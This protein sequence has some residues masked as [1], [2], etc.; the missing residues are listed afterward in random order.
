MHDHHGTTA[1]RELAGIT[2]GDQAAGQRRTQAADTFLGGARADAFVV[3]DGDLFGR[4]AHDLVGHTHRDGD[5]G[6]FVLE[7]TGGQSGSGFLLAGG[8]VLVHGVATDV[9]TLGHLFS[10]LQHVPV[11]FGLVFHEPGVG[12][13][14]GVHLL[15]HAGNGFHTTG[16]IHITLVGNDALRRRGNGLQAA[17]T[18]AVD[19]HA[20]H[21]DRAACAQGNLAGDVGTGGTFRCGAAHDDVVHLGGVN[22]GALDGV[23]H[24][25][26]TQRGAM[27]HVESTLP[28]LGERRAGGG[29]NNCGC[30]GD[31]LILCA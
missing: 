16:H 29:D 14:V 19:G 21:G 15:L 2:C 11:D 22:T 10:R 27:G 30:H 4:Q 25:V 8:T 1:V 9:V 7:Q 3:A 5:G 17:G 23:L 28:A 18:K 31:S 20:G 12:H 24:G 13:H 26:T 6:N